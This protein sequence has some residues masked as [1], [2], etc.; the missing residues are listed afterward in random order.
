[1]IRATWH[2][3]IRVKQYESESLE[4]AVEIPESDGN[5]LLGAVEE[6]SRDLSALGDRL[7]VERLRAHSSGQQ[8]ATGAS[9]GPTEPDTYL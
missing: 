7:V 2:R 1:M 4:L 5:D 8:G 3:T 9:P 6:L